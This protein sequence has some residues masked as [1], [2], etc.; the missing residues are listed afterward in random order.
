MM[1]FFKTIFGLKSR[2]TNPP[3]VQSV[4]AP[5]VQAD[6]EEEIFEP[7]AKEFLEAPAADYKALSGLA[8]VISRSDPVVGRQVEAGLADCVGFFDQNPDLFQL[9]DFDRAPES[10]QWREMVYHLTLVGSLIQG[11]YAAEFSF[12]SSGHEVVRDLNQIIDKLGL[13]VEL[14]AMDLNPENPGEEVITHISRQMPYGWSLGNICLDSDGYVLII[15]RAL[16]EARLK[17]LAGQAGLEIS[18]TF[19]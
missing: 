12:L 10:P 17:D 4:E 19:D 15:V 2:E 9:W 3:P 13:P 8:A 5:A 14:A 6:Q 7:P 16:D 11:H 1:N 18:F